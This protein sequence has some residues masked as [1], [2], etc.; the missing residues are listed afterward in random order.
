MCRS[1]SNSNTPV[2]SFS[3]GTK[4]Q[5]SCVST[6]ESDFLGLSEARCFIGINAQC[7]GTSPN[8][9]T[10]E[11]LY[12]GYLG[13]LI[14]HSPALQPRSGAVASHQGNPSP[15]SGYDVVL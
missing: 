4:L 12:S 6:R 8:H 15:G 10:P 1:S 3:I 2:F 14:N 13:K 11:S 9:S 7:S 5:S